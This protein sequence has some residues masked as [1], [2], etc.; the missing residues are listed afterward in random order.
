MQAEEWQPVND[1]KAIPTD[2]VGS[3]MYARS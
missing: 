2:S 3:R 1:V